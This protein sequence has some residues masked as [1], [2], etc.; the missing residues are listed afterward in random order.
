M[1]RMPCACPHL[2]SLCAWRMISPAPAY[3][4]CTYLWLPTN[5][6][7]AKV[8]L[9]LVASCQGVMGHHGTHNKSEV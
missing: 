6:S 8:A 2:A 1:E 9:A 3:A 4:A 5:W 7:G